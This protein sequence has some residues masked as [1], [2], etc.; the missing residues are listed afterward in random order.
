[1]RRARPVMLVAV[2]TAFSLLGDQLLYAVLPTCFAELGLVPYQVGLV[3]SVNRWV[4][5]LTNHAAERLGRCVPAGTLL[6]LALGLGAALSA[7]YAVQPAFAVLLAARALWGLSWSVIR[8]TGL[9]T[10]VE[11]ATA[12]ST[13]RWMGLYSGV[14]RVGSIAGNLVGALGYDHLGFSRTLLIFACVSLGAVPLGR[15]SQRGVHHHD[16]P[17]RGPAP[18]P[19]AAWDLLLYG[20]AVGCVGPGLVTSTLGLVMRQRM[21]TELKVAGATVGVATL[22]GFLLACGWVVELA[23]PGLG[24]LADRLGARR[25]AGLFFLSGAVALLAAAAGPGLPALGLCVVAYYVAAT[26]ASAAVSARAALSGPRGVAAYVTAWDLGSAAG[27]LLGWMGPQWGLSSSVAFAAGGLLF[28]AAGL[29][30]VRP[31]LP[32]GSNR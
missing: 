32:R 23:A 12:G 6:T 4:R 28:I 13:A 16:R 30:A 24:A 3:L 2:A 29:A 31:G 5:L 25:G 14:S 27:P 21:G 20:F 19:R 26:G 1:V 8:Q 22:T 9:M 7:L 17:G 15:L 11:C 10:V 18:A